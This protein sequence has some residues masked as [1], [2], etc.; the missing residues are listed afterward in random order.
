MCRLLARLLVMCV[1]GGAWSLVRRSS[2][3]RAAQVQ[4]FTQFRNVDDIKALAF[5]VQGTCVDFYQPVLRAGAAIN[6]DKGLAIDWTRLL[7]EW[8]D[9]YRV[10]LDAVIAG[11]RPWLRV[12]R[13]YREALDL[14]LERQG[15][16]EAFTPQE[17]DELNNVWTRLDAW[18]DTV[19]GLARLR[20]RFT[21]ATLSNAGMAAVVAV[22]KHAG[23]PFDAV[24]TAELAHSYKPAP[25]VYQLAVDFLGYRPDQI[26]MV[27]CHKYDLR[28]ARAFGM[29]TAFVARPLEFGP[30]VTPDV[31][32]EDW[33]D[34]HVDSF[35]ALADALGAG[36]PA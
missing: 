2:W 22:V 1:S 5:D 6:R 4:A 23:L 25:S 28:A 21:T 19:A 8:R 11:Q 26:V 36:S 16:G 27:A 30:D 14:L 33:L 35:T 7:A 18:P 17:R 13:I 20:R 31:T 10:A 29:R 34:L 24:L 15:L 12:D 9:L 32:A 3:K